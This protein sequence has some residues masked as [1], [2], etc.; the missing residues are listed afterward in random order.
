MCIYVI[1]YNRFKII[2]NWLNLITIQQLGWTKKE[3]LGMNEKRLS[4]DNFT[5][6]KRAEQR[7]KRWENA[8][9]INFNRGGALIK[10][11]C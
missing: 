7:Y 6:L 3:I 11:A 4:S 1:S 2:Y 5:R 10:I 8:Q 9:L